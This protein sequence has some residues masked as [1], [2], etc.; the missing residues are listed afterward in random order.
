MKKILSEIIFNV[1]GWKI[2]GINS[3]PDKC[4]VIGAPHTSNWDFLIGRC[5][6]YILG[7]N[8]KY[9]IK[10]E[11]FF[12]V[13]G[14]LLKMNGAI[15]VYRHSKNNVVDQ[16]V[17]LYNNRDKFILGMSPEGTRKKVKRWKTGFYY[18]AKKAN[19]PI[20]ILR[21]DYKKRE[22]GIVNKMN[23]SN[24]FNQD[25]MFIQKHFNKSHAKIPNNY[26]S[27]IS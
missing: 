17:A 24:D 16:I 14:F 1:L 8:A 10:S 3:F 23:V 18:I 22:I 21:I 4:L 20:L 2:I 15:P 27:I 26:N 6:G 25:M 12:P 13:F 7:V 19:I 9:L 5:Y 11:L